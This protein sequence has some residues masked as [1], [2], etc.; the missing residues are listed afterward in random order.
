MMVSKSCLHDPGNWV[1][2]P[3]AEFSDGHLP[4]EVA[5][6]APEPLGDGGGLELHG[7]FRTA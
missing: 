2:A 5:C 3:V 1:Q 4:H 6:G 7:Q